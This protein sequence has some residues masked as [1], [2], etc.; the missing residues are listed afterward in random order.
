MAMPVVLRRR[1]GHRA[2]HAG[3]EF[4]AGDVC[5]AEIAVGEP[6]QLAGREGVIPQMPNKRAL[7]G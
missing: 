3:D 6:R 7:H 5:D 4:S 2:D 1:I